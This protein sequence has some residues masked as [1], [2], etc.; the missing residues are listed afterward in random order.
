M[1]RREMVWQDTVIFITSLFFVYSLIPQVVKGFKEKEGHI[2]L[3][4]ALISTAGMGVMSLTYFSLQLYLSG[5]TALG[6]TIL[7]S[8]LLYQRIMYTYQPK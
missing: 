7:W 3:Q 1:L 6:L 4:T 5:L 8:I 2:A